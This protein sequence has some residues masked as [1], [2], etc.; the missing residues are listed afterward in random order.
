MS[1]VILRRKAVFSVAGCLLVQLCVGI[2]YLWSVLKSPFAASFGLELSAAG[3]VSSYMLTAFVVGA[4]LGGFAVDRKGPRFSCFLGLGLFAVGIGLSAFLTAGTARLIYLTYAGLGGL[5]SGIAY[6]ACISCI[7]KWMPGRRGLASGLAVS[8][9][10]LSTV[11]FAPVFKALLGLFTSPGGLVDFGPVFGILAGL[12]L[13]LGLLGCAMIRP[14][15]S[16]KAAL[17]AAGSRSLGQAVR[18]LPFWCIFLTVFFING[19]WNLATP[20]LYDL[21]LERGLSPELAT[22]ALSLTG[23][24]SAAGRLLMAAASDKLGRSKSICLLA[25]LTMAASL[26]MMVVGG[27]AYIGAVMLLAFAY[28]GPSSVN[29]AITTDYFGPRHSGSIYGVI[30]LAL[31]ASSLFFNSVSARVLGGDVSATFL[32]AALSAL[33][34]LVLMAVLHIHDALDKRSLSLSVL[35]PRRAAHGSHGA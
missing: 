34:P 6:S 7:Q 17:A 21:G 14:A 3:M 20:L 8:A 26:A 35:W 23:L 27:G 10:G 2:I 32:M 30:L 4:L 22:L 15:P 19:A 13:A 5:G 28:G 18:T 29:A 16:E 1:R 11:I 31:G 33:V 24:A 25:G 12:F 9:F